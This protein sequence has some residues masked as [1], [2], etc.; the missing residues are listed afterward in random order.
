[1]IPL[2][3]T[4]DLDKTPWKDLSSA[5]EAGLGKVTRIGRLPRGTVSGKSTVAVVIQL[6][7]GKQF[8]AETTMALF[9]AAAAGLKAIEEETSGSNARN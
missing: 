7:D 9:L 2:Q 8:I 1:M 5:A 3:V 4:T 6:P